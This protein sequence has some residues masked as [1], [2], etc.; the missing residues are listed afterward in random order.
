MCGG[1]T[2]PESSIEIGTIVVGVDVF[3]DIGVGILEGLEL[4]P[5]I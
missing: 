4:L 3:A 2:L 1:M 5:P